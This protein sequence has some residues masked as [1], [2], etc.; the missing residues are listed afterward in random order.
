MNQI[1]NFLRD[2]CRPLMMSD[3]Q[4]NFKDL[5]KKDIETSIKSLTQNNDIIIKTNGKQNIYF[6]NIQSSDATKMVSNEELRV[7]LEVNY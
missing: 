7:K 3:L 5:T 2:Q 4:S 6:Y 1:K